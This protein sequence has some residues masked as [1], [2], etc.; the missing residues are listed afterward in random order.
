MHEALITTT[1]PG[2]GSEDLE[3]ELKQVIGMDSTEILGL[4]ERQLNFELDLS[5]MVEYGLPWK[6]VLQTL[7]GYQFQIPEGN[8]TRGGN[9]TTVKTTSR[10]DSGLYLTN[11][12]LR[13]LVV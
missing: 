2:A 8:I 9:K 4:P 3:R 10:K 13:L 1:F 11:H 6:E 7:E 12:P 5:A